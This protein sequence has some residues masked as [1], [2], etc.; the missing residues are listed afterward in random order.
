MTRPPLRLMT[1]NVFEGGMGGGGRRLD[2]VASV[3]RAA[4][5]DV[6]ALCE[7]HGMAEE[8]SR[9]ADF[10]AAVG[11]RGRV[12][13][14][15]S[16]FHVALLVRAPHALAAFHGISLGGPNVLGAGLV[17]MA[18][19]G[20]VMVAVAHLE[21]FDPAVRQAEAERLAAMIDPSLPAIVLGDL[22]GLSHRDGLTRADL[23]E[24]P[25][26]HVER[27]VDQDGEVATGVTQALEAAGLVDAWRAVH[28]HAAPE[29]G[30]TV[31]TA[32]PTPPHFG[33]MRIDYVFVSGDLAGRLS[34]CEPWR[35]PPAPAASDHYPVACDLD[36]NQ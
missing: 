15:P 33:P 25:L 9:F 18:G 20:D 26:H 23:L 16:G 24:L 11:M 14:A 21:P 17:R 7:A 28:P 22:N 6:L 30:W 3:V 2:L 35:E 8:P 27:H 12:A 19:L 29:L 36:M 5:P 31:P 13:P 4:R 34:R 10:A 32:V 1:Y